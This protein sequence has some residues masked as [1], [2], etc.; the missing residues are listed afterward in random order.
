MCKHKKRYEEIYCRYKKYT[1]D[2][3]RKLW[4][5]SKSEYEK[6]GKYP[7]IFIDG[8]K[9]IKTSMEK[10]TSSNYR[11]DNFFLHG[12]DCV[13]CGLKGQYFWLEKIMI[14][15]LRRGILIYMELT[16]TG[17]RFK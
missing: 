12:T 2:E 4:E 6:T 16:K 1:I 8:D 5:W 13:S 9:K 15:E 10:K 3:V 11:Y 17:A 7:V 14:I